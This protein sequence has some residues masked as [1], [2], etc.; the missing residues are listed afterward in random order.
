MD[1]HAWFMLGDMHESNDKVLEGKAYTY[2]R[3]L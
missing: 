3:M 2:L 1:M